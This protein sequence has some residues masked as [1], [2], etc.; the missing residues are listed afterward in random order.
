MLLQERNLWAHGGGPHNKVE[1]A[2]RTATLLP[3]L[4]RAIQSAAF[5][6]QTPWI[7]VRDAR[8]RRRDGDFEVHG[9]RAMGDHPDFE[10]VSFVANEPWAEDVFYL[11]APWGPLDLTPLVVMRNCPTCHQP[12]VAFADGLDERK[13]VRYKTFDR[14]HLVFDPAMADELQNL[15]GAGR[16]T[17]EGEAG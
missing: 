9:G 14:G 3:T 7:L 15:S 10:N 12:E 11:H 1:A 8:L 2:E 5:L 6:S 17:S 13:G 4:E 16:S